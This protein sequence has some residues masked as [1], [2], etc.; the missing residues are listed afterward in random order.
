VF[1]FLNLVSGDDD[2]LV[3]VEIIFQQVLIELLAIENN[4]T[5]SQFLQNPPLGVLP[6]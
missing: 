2:R 4:E 6:H 1:D 5:E 3:F